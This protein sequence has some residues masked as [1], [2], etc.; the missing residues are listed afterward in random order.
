LGILIDII[1]IIYGEDEKSKA[2]LKS[3]LLR[4]SGKAD[5][6]AKEKLIK[7]I[8]DDKSDTELMGARSELRKLIDELKEVPKVKEIVLDN[9]EDLIELSVKDD[10]TNRNIHSYC[11][12]DKKT[13]EMKVYK[14]STYRELFKSICK[15]FYDIDNEII[16]SIADT[17]IVM[18]VKE[19]Y[20]SKVETGVRN[21]V[22]IAEDLYIERRLSP[23]TISGCI[24]TLLLEYGYMEWDFNIN[25]K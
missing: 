15:L 16:T 11:L 17:S 6:Y 1:D 21:P 14:V 13:N 9:N 20:I 4:E 18:G 2:E 22:K 23:P 7:I 8:N 25:V 19:T 10:W 5:I 12:R 3:A 24:K